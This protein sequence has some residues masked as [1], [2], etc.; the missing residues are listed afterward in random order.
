MRDESCLIWWRVLV[1][2]PSQIAFNNINK[3]NMLQL[4]LS[5]LGT[6]VSISSP[7]QKA[8]DNEYAFSEGTVGNTMKQ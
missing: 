2:T 6:G 8:G 1:A 7:L 4:P 5:A 3:L